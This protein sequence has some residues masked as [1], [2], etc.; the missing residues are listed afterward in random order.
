MVRTHDSEVRWLGVAE[1]EAW[2]A[3]I[4]GSQRLAARLEVG[5]KAHGAS[6][7]DYRILV[8]LSGAPDDRLRMADLADQSIESRSRLSHHI[9]RLEARGLVARQSCP[10]DGRGQFAV[11]LP[12]GRALIEAIAPHHVAGVRAWFVDLLTSDEL[13]VIGPAF[14]R[15]DAALTAEANR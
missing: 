14:A 13:A 5:L 10:S 15:I 12:E 9:G 6:H 2:R 4:N 8:L 11:L 7:D 3:Y 1:Q